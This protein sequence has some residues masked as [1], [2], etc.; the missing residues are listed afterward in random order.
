M[1]VLLTRPGDRNTRIALRLEQEGVDCAIWPLTRVVPLRDRID[2]PKDAEAIVFSSG[3][4]VQIFAQLSPLRALP[5][6]TVGRRTAEI[7]LDAGFS[8]VESA[9][10][11]IATLSAH[12]AQ[13][14]HRHVVH[15]RGRDTAGDLPGALRQHDISVSERII[16]SV[17]PAGP[18][19]SQ[20][21]AAMV[22]GEVDL[23]TLW[24]AR[25]GRVLISFLEDHPQIDAARISVL[26]I[27]KRVAD[28]FNVFKVRGISISAAP[29]AEAMIDAVLDHQGVER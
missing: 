18:P 6:V 2:F 19:D 10:G 13:T 15:V 12:I 7:A 14:E 16:Y 4:A 8:D 23:I 11:N 20:V 24:S 22:R 27:S 28:E 29:N 3:N 25:A 1:A 21:A 26:A 9:D 17:L 5:V